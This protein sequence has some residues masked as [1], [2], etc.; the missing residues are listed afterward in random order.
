MRLGK[1]AAPSEPHSLIRCVKWCRCS[2][3]EKQALRDALEIN[4]TTILPIGNSGKRVPSPT[5]WFLLSLSLH[6]NWY[7]YTPL[8]FL[9][10]PRLSNQESETT[11]GAD[12]PKCKMLI[13]VM[14]GA[15][16]DFAAA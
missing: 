6:G 12:L 8:C 1:Q 10:R 9:F 2:E 16:Y 11:R 14:R 5:I 3:N 13:P 7:A 15:E 4:A